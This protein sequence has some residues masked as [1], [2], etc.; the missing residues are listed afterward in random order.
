[1]NNK[2]ET[3]VDRDIEYIKEEVN[4]L[5]QLLDDPYPQMWTWN[6]FCAMRMKNISDFYLKIQKG[7][8]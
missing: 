6:S 2:E 3:Q 5:K 8:K 4:K 7:V 1:M